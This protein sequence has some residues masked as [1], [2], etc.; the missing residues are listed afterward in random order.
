MLASRYRL[1]TVEKA[2]ENVSPEHQ[3][4]MVL[5]RLTRELPVQITALISR[6]CFRRLPASDISPAHE[7]CRI[8]AARLIR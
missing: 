5:L 2:D 8:A 3:F 7:I 6:D 4:A 1:R